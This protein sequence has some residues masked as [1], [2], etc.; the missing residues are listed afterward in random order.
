MV[1][2]GKKIIQGG[3]T[4]R[5]PPSNKLLM[6]KEYPKDDTPPCKWC[7]P[8]REEEARDEERIG[9]EWYD[10]AQRENLRSVQ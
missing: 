9:V 6:N 5:P 4:I 3:S 1:K 7:S 10:H 8:T 2:C